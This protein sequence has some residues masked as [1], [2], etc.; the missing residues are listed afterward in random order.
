VSAVNKLSLFV[1]TEQRRLLKTW[2]IM[3]LE[4]KLYRWP[5]SENEIVILGRGQLGPGTIGAMIPE[6]DEM[7]YRALKDHFERLASKAS[8]NTLVA[9]VRRTVAE[10]IKDGKPELK[11]VAGALKLG[12]RTLQRRLQKCGVDFK[13]LA[14]EV[15]CQLATSYLT[16]DKKTLTE[17]ALLLGYSEVSA[18]N[19]AFKRWTNKTPLAYRR[20]SG[21]SRRSVAG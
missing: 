14:S 9:E 12:P 20:L 13:E 3:D 2:E 4:I 15:R 7:L 21:R 1:K 18:F 19:R 5:S 8:P 17:I 11:R 6:A 10:F 16:E